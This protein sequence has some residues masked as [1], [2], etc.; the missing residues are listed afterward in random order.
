MRGLCR[1]FG[2]LILIITLANCLNAQFAF[3]AMN[4]SSGEIVSN[5]N[6][7][8]LLVPA[9]IQKVILA[10]IAL[11]DLGADFRFETQIAYSGSIDKEGVLRGDIIIR[12]GGDPTL[13][14][15]YDRLNS[16]D[17]LQEMVSKVA[18]AG[19]TCID[20]SLVID[21]SIWG[22]NCVA[23]TWPWYDLGNYY[24]AGAW[25]LN[26]CDNAHDITF[27][28]SDTR[29][30]GPQLISSNGPRNL[31]YT[32]E[33]V[34]GTR[35]S[36]DQAY[37]Y[38]APFQRQRY[39]RGSLPLGEGKF[40][41]RGS[42]PEPPRYFAEAL[43]AQLTQIG[44]QVQN[45]EIVRYTPVERKDVRKILTLRSAQLKDIL[46]V[47]LLKSDNVY[48]EAIFR[49]L[50]ASSTYDKALRKYTQ[51]L[52]KNGFKNSILYD[53]C[54]LS[55]FNRISAMELANFLKYS[56]QSQPELQS[57]LPLIDDSSW[58]S[59]I[60]GKSIRIKS[61]YMEGVCSYCGI[62]N[63]DMVFVA[64]YN[65][66]DFKKAETKKKLAGFLHKAL[67]H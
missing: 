45:G 33:L 14:S 2:L 61:G 54:G 11:S 26:Y 22:S 9:S 13:A 35:G 8:D 29:G 56:L 42:I 47:M 36:G 60:N 66:Q 49:T 48:A 23:P 5:E 31:S 64:I 19:I 43:V 25:G 63:N 57:V 21:A 53:G 12:G 15:K 34:T 38:G 10:S 24:A 59:F 3:V 28:L 41:I 16:S 20:G 6:G 39:I 18:K 55:P 46:K 67:N 4:A 1:I 40:S 62:A 7:D 51:R 44:I 52:E 30:K 65:G 17:V 37:V 50:S 27:V 32:N 58:R